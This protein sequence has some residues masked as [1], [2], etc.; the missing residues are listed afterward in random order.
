MLTDIDNLVQSITEMHAS[1]KMQLDVVF[2]KNDK[3]I[4]YAPAGYGKTTTMVSR[5]AYLC[6]VGA[7]PNPK[8]VLGLTF[9][10]NAA[11]KI[12]RD[13]SEK[14]PHI[15]G[16]DKN[17]I[18][19]NNQIIVS[20]YHGLS[21]RIL[22]KYGYLLSEELKKDIAIFK[23]VNEENAIDIEELEL[24]DEEKFYLVEF[25][26]II[27]SGSLPTNE[28]IDYYLKIISEKFLNKNTITHNAIILYVLSL[29]EKYESIKSFYQ[30]YFSCIIVDEFQDTNSI[31][32]E[33]LKHLICDET[34]L[35]FLGDP[36]QRIYGFIGALPKIMDI[37]L[38]E[39]SMQRIVLDT[40]YRFRNN[41]NMLLLDK[42]IRENAKTTFNGHIEDIANIKAF[43][44]KDQVD[45][46]NKIAAMIE[47]LREEN[48]G[49]SIAILSRSRNSN[50]DVIEAVLA[51]K[52]ID[53]FYGMFSEEDPEYINFHNAC[54]DRFI[55]KFGKTKSIT[56]KTLKSF[57]DQIKNHVKSTKTN[58][59][60]VSLLI[61]LTQKIDSDYCDLSPE[62]KYSLILEIFENR[63]LKQ[64]MDYIN[65]DI[66]LT[67][68]HGS[69][70]LEW[71]YV[72]L[73]DLE[74]WIFPGYQV[75]INCPSKSMSYGCY[76]KLPKTIDNDFIEPIIDELSVFY[77]GVTRARKEVFVSGS[78]KRLN[79]K[80][81]LNDSKFSCLASLEG[82]KL[83]DGSA[84]Q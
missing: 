75:C 55:A 60:M 1:D 13:I 49:E 28:S 54:Q 63:Q 29:F 4:V 37:A 78:G 21:K 22:K 18:S 80:K 69:K 38:H 65:T 10:V 36:L 32:W 41:S 30:K 16:V 82:L 24:N 79:W 52:N 8:K 42:N 72:F 73:V 31:S 23:A 74:R 26:K 64:S 27:K 39:Y 56:K 5:L 62:E 11:L 44:G 59:S 17:Q 12:K 61:A 20:N 9:S 6:V 48:N 43:Y 34:K 83:I 14:L 70:G 51:S 45:E 19:I 71:D 76:C 46:A 2:S 77:V 81:D 7:I 84:Y 66:I 25:D 40:N 35:L 47:R 33:L 50:V 67:T 53:Y 58:D 3:V 57:V 15:L 68:V